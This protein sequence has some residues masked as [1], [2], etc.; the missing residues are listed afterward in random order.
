MIVN[1][2]PDKP[3]RELDPG[4]NIAIISKNVPPRKD[5]APGTSG[6]DCAGRPFNIARCAPARL[7]ERPGKSRPRVFDADRI[8][9][10]RPPGRW[11]MYHPA[12]GL[13]RLVMD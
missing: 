5:H 10:L 11:K 9:R 8:D 4:C 2:K 3:G 7:P 6:R 12:G 1:H 13:V